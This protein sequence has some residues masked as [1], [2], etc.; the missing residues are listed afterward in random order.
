MTDLN[1]YPIVRIRRERV[2]V[3]AIHTHLVGH[4]SD[5]RQHLGVV[6]PSALLVLEDEL[7]ALKRAARESGFQQVLLPL[8][9]DYPS[10]R[11]ERLVVM[12][13]LAETLFVLHGGARDLAEEDR[14]VVCARQLKKRVVFSDLNLPPI[15]RW[16]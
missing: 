4:F 5:L 10:H 15:E 11:T 1:R 8:V 2:G 16:Q 6:P 7:E 3:I 14:H 13:E 9:I 12:A